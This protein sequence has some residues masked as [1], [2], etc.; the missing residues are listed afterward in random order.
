MTVTNMLPAVLVVLLLAGFV[1]SFIW[2]LY[3]G[4]G[5]VPSEEGSAGEERSD[6]PG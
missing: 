2:R 1:V 4:P 5:D 6:A 3:I